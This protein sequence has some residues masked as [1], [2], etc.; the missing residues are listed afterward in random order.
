MPNFLIDTQ[1]PP[2][3]SK[4]LQSRGYESV[5]TMDYP[6]GHLLQD[7]EII[8]IATDN[9]QVIITKD[10]DFLDNYLLK[11]APP[12]VLLLEVGN[13]KNADL[14]QIFER[15]IQTIENA[16]ANGAHLVVIDKTNLIQF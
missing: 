14:L 4:F 8:K 10:S 7:S 13:I 11:G 3:L 15:N 6:E 5:H 9:Q 16:F 12:D 1:L 2:A